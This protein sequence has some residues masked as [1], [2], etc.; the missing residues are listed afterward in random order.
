MRFVRNW[1]SA[2]GQL[3]TSKAFLN[4]LLEH[5][6]IRDLAQS[7]LLLTMICLYFEDHRDL[8]ISRADLYSKGLDTI[9]ERWDASRGIQREDSAYGR[10]STS[11]KES[12]YSEFAL[13]HLEKG[14][15]IF[16]SPSL[17]EFFEE[18]EIDSSAVLQIMESQHGLLIQRAHG[19]YSFSHLTFQEYLAAKH[20][21]EDS[22][23]DRWDRLL[24]H[25]PDHRWRE[26]FRLVTSMLQA[27]YLVERMKAWLDSI[28]RQSSA[29]QNVLHWLLRK[30]TNATST[31]R[32]AAIRAFYLELA[33]TEVQSKTAA[34]DRAQDLTFAFA[35]VLDRTF[36]LDPNLAF[37]YSLA[38]VSVS[39]ST[40]T[41][42]RALAHR[43]GI[44]E[45][46]RVLLE[47]LEQPDQR[48]QFP[49]RLSRL[50]TVMKEHRDIGHGIALGNSDLDL[51][52]D[53]VNGHQALIDCLKTARISSSVRAKIENSLFLPATSEA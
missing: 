31:S 51:L 13:K 42:P 45:V 6:G 35:V 4:S 48:E 47:A 43:L 41:R 37:D 2:R 40:L 17:N 7:P 20:F 11:G 19:V 12:L 27:A 28:A 14:E 1:F 3:E 25:L 22:A 33:L 46:F 15:V 50:K 8:N 44:Y 49:E 26:V 9:L 23:P 38:H 21:V 29:V 32:P 10:L 16:G 39:S 5:P 24:P 53:Y 36:V 52:A 30:Q 18:E 34:L